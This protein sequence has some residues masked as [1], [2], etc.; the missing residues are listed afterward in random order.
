MIQ[1]L[2]RTKMKSCNRKGKAGDAPSKG[3]FCIAYRAQKLAEQYKCPLIK[4][5]EQFLKN[6]DM[7]MEARE[8]IK[9]NMKHLETMGGGKGSCGIKKGGM[10]GNDVPI[11]W[12]KNR[13]NIV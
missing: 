7:G 8:I 4:F 10:Q 12:R 6:N 3:E 1:G 2:M 13:G 11:I 9:E 5:S